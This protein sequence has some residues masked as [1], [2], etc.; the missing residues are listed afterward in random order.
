MY[1]CNYI[2]MYNCM[3]MYNYM[4][5]YNYMFRHNYMHTFN[6]CLSKH[7][8]EYKY[9]ATNKNKVQFKRRLG[10]RCYEHIFTS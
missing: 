2:Y 10:C 4:Y 8:V 1:T 6:L 9:T 5:I 3:Y 7:D